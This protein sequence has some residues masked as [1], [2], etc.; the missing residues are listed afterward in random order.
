[1]LG[2]IYKVTE[3]TYLIPRYSLCYTQGYVDM[4]IISKNFYFME[5]GDM[6]IPAGIV[7]DTECFLITN[8]S[9][10]ASKKSIDRETT[11]IGKINKRYFSFILTALINPHRERCYGKKDRLI[12]I[13]HSKC[14]FHD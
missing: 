12:D 7:L 8:R 1:M 5:G 2:G 14:L 11:F 3:D 9:A 13:L 10:C 6:L 4:A